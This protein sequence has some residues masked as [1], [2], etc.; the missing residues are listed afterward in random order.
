MDMKTNKYAFLGLCMAAASCA[1]T[2]TGCEDFFE[3]DSNQLVYAEGGHLNQ[4]TD[5]VY[6]MMGI[7]QKMQAIADRTVLLGELRG[8][9][10]DLG[11]NTPADLRNLSLFNLSDSSNIYNQ[12]RDYYAV[13][14]NCNYFIA[15]A[16]TAMRDN[17]NEMVFMR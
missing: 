3:Q 2:F 16:D 9:L 17:R 13:I 11:V 5:T 6:S 8:D 7:L 14:N 1:A 10:V 4:P 12:P 15:N